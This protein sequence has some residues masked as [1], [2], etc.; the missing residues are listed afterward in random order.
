[1]IQP[2]QIAWFFGQASLIYI[3]LMPMWPGVHTGYGSVIR[4]GCAVLPDNIGSAASV[5]LLPLEADKI[6]LRFILN[7]RGYFSVG[8]GLSS[9]IIGYLPMALLI[10]LVLSTPIKW[11]RRLKAL[12]WSVI[13][14]HSILLF[15]VAFAVYSQFVT[16]EKLALVQLDTFWR[17]LIFYFNHLMVNSVTTSFTI[18]LIIWMV[19]SFR[20][21]DW[22]TIAQ[23]EAD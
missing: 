22:A 15:R 12:L 5:T 18:S 1:M 13:L 19:V 7:K 11:K 17:Y 8:L 10:A 6:D 3:L 21:D 4:A 16:N 23:S 2:K 9:R 14:F 20:R